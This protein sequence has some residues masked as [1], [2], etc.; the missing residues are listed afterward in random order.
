MKVKSHLDFGREAQIIQ[1]TLQKATSL[2]SPGWAGGVV[3]LTTD[4]KVYFH[5]GSE[6][7]PINDTSGLIS[8]ITAGAGISIIE[9]GS[10]RKVVF[11]PDNS[12][13]DTESGDGGKAKIKD[14]GVKTQH[15]D[16]D[17]VDN[18]KLAADAVHTVHILNNN[19]TF[20]KIQKIPTM[21]VIGHL[22][23]GTET[24]EGV[25]VIT[26]L[27]GI[28]SANDSLA[29][30]KAVKDYVDGIV[31]GIGSLVD[32]WD[33][34]ANDNFPPGGNKGDYWYITNAGTIHEI[35]FVEG[36]VIIARVNNASTTDPADWIPLKTKRGQATTTQLGIVK[37]S[38]QAQARA[39]TDTEKV[40]TPSN[41]SDV[42]ATDADAQGSTND[43]FVT[44]QGLHN[45]T[46]TTTRRGIAELA[47]QSEV[48]SGTDNERIVTPSTLRSL[49]NE[50]FAEFGKHV[51]N[52]GNGSATSFTINHNLETKDVHTEVYCNETGESVIVDVLRTTTQ[53]VVVSFAEAPDVNAYRIVI[54]K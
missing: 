54:A 44:P 48:N 51:Q 41:L 33:A 35:A 47:T 18:E 14:K 16:D 19:V 49:L 31:G 9:S 8:N 37:L 13:L 17:A 10:E 6:W 43:R 23:S 20:S 29:T 2:P 52:I 32:G 15:I 1:I 36:D 22:G 7:I 3:F 4:N 25:S 26:S 40:L 42:K 30:A 5:N 38:T 21:T 45:R 24:P 53:A 28:I 11:D 39:M 50:L 27:V 34:D 46:A 12:T